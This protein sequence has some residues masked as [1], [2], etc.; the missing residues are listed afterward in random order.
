M[1][2]RREGI[3]AAKGCGLQSRIRARGA[4]S[5]LIRIAKMVFFVVWLRDIAYISL[6]HE[7]TLE[8]EKKKK[9]KITSEK[10]LGE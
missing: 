7:H 10:S 9:V 6:V 4:L 8:E 3:P 1:E 2:V 5:S